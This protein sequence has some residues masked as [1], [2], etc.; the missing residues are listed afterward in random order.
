M[1]P[2]RWEQVAQAFETV[3]ACAADERPR[4][5]RECC[6]E[7]LELAAEV[8]ALLASA[9]AASDFLTTPPRLEPDAGF[10]P[11]PAWGPG[12]LLAGR[13]EI[14]GLL[15]RG[16]MGEVYA[17]RDLELNSE[18]AV[19]RVRAAIAS[20]ARALTRFKREVLMARRISHPH[21]CR[22]H[23][24]SS[25]GGDY[26]LT[27]ELLR[28]P[29]L[30]QWLQQNG[31]LQPDAA[32]RVLEEVAAGLDAAHAAGIV[33]RDLKPGNVILDDADGTA[34]PRAVITDFGLARAALEAQEAEIASGS[35]LLG[36]LAYMSPEQLSGLPVTPASDLYSFGLI[37]Y[38]VLTGRAAY[39]GSGPFAGVLQ[40]LHG[41]FPR[42]SQVRPELGVGWDAMI[43]GCLE[44]DPARRFPSATAAM[45]TVP[46][47]RR[48]VPARRGRGWLWVAAAAIFAALMALSV[49]L[50]RFIHVRADIQPGAEVLLTPVVNATQDPELNGATVALRQQLAQSAQFRL[51]DAAEIAQQMQRMGRSAPATDAGLAE[52]PQLARELAMRAGAPLVIFAELS[53]LAGQFRLELDLQRVGNDPDAPARSWSHIETAANKDGVFDAIHDA[54]LWVRQQAGE[55]AA[56]MV[57]T[58]QPTRDIT[59]PS[60][61]ALALYS[62]S[63]AARAA[64]QVDQALALL[65][66]AIS[67]DPKFAL[68]YTR[69]GDELA[70]Q[71]RNV[72]ADAAYRTAL[73]LARDSRRLSQRERLLL[74]GDYDT[75]MLN[76]SGAVSSFQDYSALY[77]NDYLGWFYQG[78]PEFERGRPAAAAAAWR[79]AARLAPRAGVVPANVA[80]AD[81]FNDDLTGAQ[82]AISQSRALLDTDVAIV[83]AGKLRMIGHDPKG[84]LRQFAALR[85]AREPVWLQ[86]A[87]VL[88]AAVWADAGQVGDAQRIL[89]DRLAHATDQDE[90]A[91]LHADL[92]YLALM[93][94]QPNL[95][96]QEAA[97]ALRVPQDPMLLESA[98]ALLARAGDLDSA[99]TALLDLRKN[100]DLQP[101]EGIA[102]NRLQ[103][104][105]LLAQGHAVAAVSLFQRAHAAAPA[106]ML[107]G[108][109]ARALVA[110]GRRAEAHALLQPWVVSPAR[111]W[112]FQEYHFPGSY[113]ELVTI[114]QHNEH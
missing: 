17:A 10:A 82:R 49:P 99:R 88:E 72:E 57:A 75:D 35:R 68:A 4:R 78:I 42:P 1:S 69:L 102:A 34:G 60:W 12:T 110:A 80:Y 98:G 84:A 32:R 7:D 27:M 16:G 47:E 113:R 74:L 77:P 70:S 106:T 21:V 73:R 96:R 44:E 30:T 71:H 62:R 14:V 25:A 79:Q 76:F 3:Q 91:R 103:G 33:H 20:D 58:D 90:Q 36:T 15:G 105:I 23:D 63:Q 39:A 59:T 55:T 100:R 53:R 87:P 83:L 64:G 94:G 40:R 45:A 50:Y 112:S 56:D 6:G 86:Y 92:A 37:A 85:S 65:H 28:G 26:F 95:V 9:D 38:E 52:Q 8:E 114:Y 11:A 54:A 18:V 104:E 2:E 41:A 19:K 97:A 51:L 61:T 107:P 5:L 89:R 22:I 67:A 81:L 66:A 31:P 109:L 13:F 93:A 43:A 101:L 48:P 24:L 108:D 29:T 46:Q 111:V